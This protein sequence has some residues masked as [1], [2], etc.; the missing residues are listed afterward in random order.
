MENVFAQITANESTL[1]T[2][3]RSPFPDGEGL[4]GAALR[5]EYKKGDARSV[6]GE[7]VSHLCFLPSTA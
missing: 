5:V 4:G 2:A 7:R 3:S 1:S 6:L